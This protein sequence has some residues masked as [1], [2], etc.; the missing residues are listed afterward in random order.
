MGVLGPRTRTERLLAE[1]AARGAAAA[2][3]DR[4]FGPV[5]LD[6]GGEGPDAI[7]LAIVAEVAAVASG[8]PGGHLRDRQTPSPARTLDPHAARPSRA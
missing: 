7:A 6:L 3:G 1:L 5:G 4:L 2:P 8:R